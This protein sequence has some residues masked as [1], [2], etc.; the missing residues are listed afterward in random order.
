MIYFIIFTEVQK[1][2][3]TL[4]KIDLQLFHCI[5]LYFQMN[6]IKK[7]I[8]MYPRFDWLNYIRYKIEMLD[9]K[10]LLL[11]I[12]VSI[13]ANYYNIFIN[14]YLYLYIYIGFVFLKF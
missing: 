2:D 1:I 7:N 5:W 11:H 13:K 10:L 14:I 3:Q 8:H 4:C 6:G 9:C 12:Y